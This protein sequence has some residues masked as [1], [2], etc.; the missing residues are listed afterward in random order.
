MLYGSAGK[1]SKETDNFYRYHNGILHYF[2]IWD[3][4][5]HIQR[6]MGVPEGW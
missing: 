5:I 3:I 4:E 6:A 2:T 1:I